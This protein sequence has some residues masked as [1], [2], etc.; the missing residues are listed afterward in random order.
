M[1]FTTLFTTALKRVDLQCN[2][3]LSVGICVG[4]TEFHKNEIFYSAMLCSSLT[5]PGS[6]LECQM[7]DIF[8]RM[9][10]QDHVN[11][12]DSVGMTVI[13]GKNSSRVITDSNIGASVVLSVP[14]ILLHI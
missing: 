11:Y 12:P 5:V 6:C 3:Q 10:E 9:L 1:L 7:V 4:K 2:N 8:E 13:Q 14:T